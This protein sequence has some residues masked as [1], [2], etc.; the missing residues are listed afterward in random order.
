MSE[1][2]SID[3]I[4]LV[5]SPYKEKFGIPRQPGLAPS[6]TSRIEFLPEYSSAD[7]A[8]GLEGCSHLWLIF[9]FNGCIDQGWKPTVRPPRLG[10]NKRM[11]VYATRSPFR[12]NP[13]GLSAVKL[14]KIEFKD[15]RLILTVSGADLLDGTPIVDVKPYLP[16]SDNL[17]DAE[18]TLA[19]RPQ[20][21]NL[22]VRFSEKAALNCQRES[23]AHQLPLQEQ[24]TELLQS[25]PRPAYKQT[26]PDRVFGI[27][28]HHL[29]I[30]FRVTSDEI[31]VEEIN[32]ALTQASDNSE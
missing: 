31:I 29:N 28:L 9:I 25:D 7:I 30:R 27:R 18:F 19:D 14:E 4:A 2:Y 16:Y 5:R 10:G 22:N 1:S 11:G 32:Q 20:L 12:P 24:I 13:I 15:G 8:R 21:L 17:P 3:T 23:A 26:D 6:L